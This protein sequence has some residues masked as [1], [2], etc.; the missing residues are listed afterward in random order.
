MVLTSGIPSLT[1]RS[2]LNTYK[3]AKI[4]ATRNRTIYITLFRPVLGV[5]DIEVRRIDSGQKLALYN[6]VFRGLGPPNPT[7]CVT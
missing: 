7:V 2:F 6:K 4:C 3:Y 5:V 1:Y